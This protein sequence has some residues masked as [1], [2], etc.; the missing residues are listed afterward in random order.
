MG[1]KEIKFRVWNGKLY[2]VIGID[3]ANDKIIHIHVW[4]N[5][6]NRNKTLYPKDEPILLQFTGLKDKNGKEIYEG[7]I[8]KFKN[9]LGQ[10]RISVVKYEP[11]WAAFY[12]EDDEM[13]YT[14]DFMI[15]TSEIEIIGN[16][17]E[18]KELLKEVQ[19]AKNTS[20]A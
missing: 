10:E 7:D 20:Q 14:F 17:Y 12:V 9:D 13:K 3:W 4:D 16:F 6:I 18:N 2:K 8:I 19:N 5:E 11:S 15:D 1:L